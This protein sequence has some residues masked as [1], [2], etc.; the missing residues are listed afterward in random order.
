MGTGR[1]VKPWFVWRPWQL[2][3]RARFEWS[4]PHGG[5]QLLRVAWGVSLVADPRMMFGR[6]IQTTGIYDLAV[7]EI[8][9]RLVHAGSTVI[10]GGAHVGYTALLAALA[11]AP[12]GHVIAWEPNPDLFAVLERNL[13]GVR[14]AKITLRNA[15]LGRAAG[16]GKLVLPDE[17]SL[18]DGLSH[19]EQADCPSARSIPVTIEAIDDIVGATPVDVMKLDVEGVEH[20]VLDGAS[21]ALSA[22]RIRHIVFEDHRGPASDVMQRLQSMGYVIFAIGWSLRGLKLGPIDGGPLTNVYEAPNYVATLAPEEVRTQCKKR[23]WMTLS[24]RFADEAVSR[25]HGTGS[26]G[27]PC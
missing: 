24:A 8:L 16:C 3:R 10:D 9:A 18:N 12:D 5:R 11:A 4:G 23:G 21:Q 2:A 15:A 1:L 22:G 14:T 6:S 25:P 13:A 27:E 26:R 19:L 20:L 7:T 17:H